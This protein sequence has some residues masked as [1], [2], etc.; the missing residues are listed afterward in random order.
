MNKRNWLETQG[1]GRGRKTKQATA[2][3]RVGKLET[4]SLGNVALPSWEAERQ[5]GTRRRDHVPP[6]GQLPSG[7]LC[8]PPVSGEGPG[9]SRPLQLCL[10]APPGSPRAV[11]ALPLPEVRK[12]LPEKLKETQVFQQVSYPLL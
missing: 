8:C 9:S 10:P 4:G 5:G 3:A 11:G 6:E 2:V 12:T 7:W 1:L